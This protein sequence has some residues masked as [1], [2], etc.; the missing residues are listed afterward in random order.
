L[1]CSSSRTRHGQTDSK[2]KFDVQTLL[3]PI[4]VFAY[5]HEVS[6]VIHGHADWTGKNSGTARLNE[7]S[8]LEESVARGAPDRRCSSVAGLSIGQTISPLAA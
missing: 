2:H 6:H 7:Y 3:I 5:W 8:G 1:S 4:L